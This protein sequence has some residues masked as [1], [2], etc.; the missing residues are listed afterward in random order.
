VRLDLCEWY[1]ARKGSEG[2]LAQADHPGLAW[3]LVKVRHKDG[4]ITIA[5]QALR[6]YRPEPVSE[7]ETTLWI[8]LHLGVPLSCPLTTRG[9]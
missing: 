5:R 9:P 2:S 1:T 3:N 6:R 8:Q 7:D 4:K